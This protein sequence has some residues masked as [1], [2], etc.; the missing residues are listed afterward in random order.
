MNHDLAD[1]RLGASLSF[2][3]NATV[4]DFQALSKQQTTRTHEPLFQEASYKAI[5]E[6]L[7]RLESSTDPMQ[8]KDLST[9]QQQAGS[10]ATD[11]IAQRLNWTLTM[12]KYYQDLDQ[13]FAAKYHLKR[14]Q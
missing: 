1:V 8:I 13:A 6:A 3:K 5:D 10:K 7:N 14:S 12:I 9:W 2:S 11:P 4:N